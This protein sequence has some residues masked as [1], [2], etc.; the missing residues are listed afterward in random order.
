MQVNCPNC[1]EKIAA[2]NINIHKMVAVCSACD[3]VFP[4][5][6]PESKIKRRKVKQPQQLTLRDAENLHMSFRTNFRLGEN[7][8]FIGSAVG[9]GFLTFFTLLMTNEY[10]TDGLT[11]LLPLG[12]GLAALVMYYA[13][14]LIVF[15]KTY[16][17]MD[18][19]KISVSRKPLPNILAQDHEVNLS[20][21]VKIVCEE[22]KKSK[23][24]A[25][26][27]PRYRVLAETV[28]GSQ[29]MIVNDVIEDYAYFIAQRLEERLHADSDF[30][31]SHLEDI[32]ADSEGQ[33]N[34][35]NLAQNSIEASS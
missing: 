28:D 4:F 35:H 34:I 8:A 23:K 20:G 25:Y 3:T 1:G 19:N 26:D 5:D 32:E 15:N 27:V 16:I 12:F 22:T 9:S 7:E 33:Q 31:M 2:E 30:D 14:A 11:P 17:K 24:E 10:L 13:V 21:V 6:S 29:K 18:E